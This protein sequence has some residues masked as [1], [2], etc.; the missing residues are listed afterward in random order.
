M[1]RK[2]IIEHKI[3]KDEKTGDYIICP[4]GI[5]NPEV[6]YCVTYCAAY[7][8][9]DCPNGVVSRCKMFPK[10]DVIGVIDTRKNNIEDIKKEL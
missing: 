1:L 3:L 2:I 7:E 9:S 6:P 8:E 4:L 5:N 10:N